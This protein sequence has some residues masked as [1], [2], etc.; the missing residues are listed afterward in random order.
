V[1]SRL[2]PVMSDHLPKISLRLGEL[3]DW[4]DQ[5]SGWAMYKGYWGI[6]SGDTKCS[7][8]VASTAKAEEAELHNK[9]ITAW[10]DVDQCAAGAIL[11]MLSA[12]ECTALHAHRTSGGALY[13]A[14]RQRHVQEKPASRYNAYLEFLGLCCNDGEELAAFVSRVQDAMCHVQECCP[15]TF[16]IKDLDSDLMCMATLHALSDDPSCVVHV[17]R[18]LHSADKLSDIDKLKTE[19]VDEDMN[20]RTSP[21]LYGLKADTQGVLGAA[22][23]VDTANAALAAVAAAQKKSKP[24]FSSTPALSEHLLRQL[25]LN[26]LRPLQWEK[27]N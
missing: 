17:S 2:F 4:D 24:V 13:A 16:S 18:L 22:V 15:A 25:L 20:H 9:E 1:I 19:L 12:E 8:P 3:P 11:L 26:R 5:F 23:I 10:T 21:A 27:G 6:I 14:I 7:D